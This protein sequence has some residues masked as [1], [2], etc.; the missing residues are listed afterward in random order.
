VQ[1][2]ASLRTKKNVLCRLISQ[3]RLGVN[4]AEAIAKQGSTGIDIQIPGSVQDCQILCRQTQHLIRQLEKDSIQLHK[5]ELENKAMALSQ[6]GDKI[7]S[8]RLRIL[9]KAEQTKYLFQKLTKIRNVTKQGIT[10]LEVPT[11]PLE[12]NYKECRE[13]ITITLPQEIKEKL[14]QRNQ[15]HFGQAAGSFPTVSPFSEWVDWT[16]NSH[17]AELILEGAFESDELTDIQQLLLAHMK[18]RTTLD[19]ISNSVTSALFLHR[20]K[21]WPERATTSPSGFHLGH[22]KALLAEHDKNLDSPEGIFIEE[23]HKKLRDWQI[24]LLNIA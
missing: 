18:S 1:Q 15:G 3:T 9:L 8:K 20:I 19:V 7:N 21:K 10:K 23:C 5:Q 17:V 22:S 13:W 12:T 24:R 4:M 16:E 11:D 6:Q 14:R 2:L